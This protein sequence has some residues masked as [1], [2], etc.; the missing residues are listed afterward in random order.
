MKLFLANT[1]EVIYSREG[2]TQ[3]GPESM[4]FY[5]VSAAMLSNGHKGVQSKKTFYA[6]GGS[7]RGMLDGL[8]KWW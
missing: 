6:D 7:G 2:T 8:L 5:A 4:G 1:N 3:G